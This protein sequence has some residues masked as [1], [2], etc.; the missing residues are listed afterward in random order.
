LFQRFCVVGHKPTAVDAGIR[1]RAPRDKY[2][3]VEQRKATPLVLNRRIE[4]DLAVVATR[5]VPSNSSLHHGAARAE[6]HTGANVNRAYPLLNRA[7]IHDESDKVHRSGGRIDDR[8]SSNAN[9][10][11]KAR[12]APEY[13]STSGDSR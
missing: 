7:V 3:T 2:L 11:T 1:K 9:L 6:V 5:S 8:S 10:R 12:S 4:G 13:G